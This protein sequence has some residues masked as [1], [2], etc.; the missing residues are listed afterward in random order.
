VKPNVGAASSP[1][2]AG[3]NVIANV[4][5][6]GALP[7]TNKASF[8]AEAMVPKGTLFLEGYAA[9]LNGQPG[10]LVQVFAGTREA[11]ILSASTFEDLTASV[12]GRP[13][14]THAAGAE[15]ASAQR[16]LRPLKWV[17]IAITAAGLATIAYNYF[18][19]RELTKPAD[20]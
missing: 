1:W 20:P 2:L 5:A 15:L 11:R 17:G 18:G 13:L 8:I 16:L 7:A 12:A 6:R 3:E 14:V 9:P 4:T 10:G 19:D